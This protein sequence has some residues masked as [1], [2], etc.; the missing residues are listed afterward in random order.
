MRTPR[1]PATMLVADKTFFKPQSSILHE[2]FSGAYRSNFGKLKVPYHPTLGPP[3]LSII[4]CPSFNRPSLQALSGINVATDPDCQ[5]VRSDDSFCYLLP[6]V[7]D[8][9]EVER[10]EKGGFH[11]VHLGD[12]YNDG[13][14]R[15]VHKIG[16]G[17]YS[18]AWLAHDSQLSTWVA[19][20]IVVADKSAVFEEKV[21]MCHDF[22]SAW[23]DGRI[24]TYSHLFN[25]DGPNGHHLC[26]VLPFLGPSA[27][28]MSN[29]LRSRIHPKLVRS[30]ISQIA[31]TVADLH[32]HGLCHGDIT[33]SNI[34]FRLRN[35]E[36]LDDKGIY[37]LFGEPRTAPLETESGEVPGLEA[38]RYIVGYLDFMAS[39]EDLIRDEVCLIDFDQAFLASKPPQKVLGTPPGFLAPEVAVGIPAGPASDVWALTSTLLHLRSGTSPFAEF[40]MD[41]PADQMVPIAQYLGPLPNSWGDPIFDKDG[42]PIKDGTAGVPL[43]D[44]LR[45]EK[46][47][48]RDA[49]NQIFDRP[50]DSLH[51]QNPPVRPQILREDPYPPCYETKF[52]RPGSINI[53]GVYLRGYNDKVDEIIKSLPKISKHEADLLYDLVSKVFV[54]EPEKRPSAEDVLRHPWFQF[55]DD[56]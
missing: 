6:Q 2:R 52:W 43:S 10:Y 45:P 30:V 7:G 39:G 40:A 37:R 23:A 33:P 26:L 47:S 19:L 5:S 56:A 27:Y 48:L 35:L 20:K 31:R 24:V 11:T 42:F 25:I 50:P 15:I 49:I 14:Y 32:S 8:S 3:I 36:H 22:T 29:F 12:L 38:P 1:P 53:D 4:I 21:K 34:V 28:T 17:G 54:Y 41:A 55:Q 46:L 9:E 44:F 51:C 18:T 13:R 16:S